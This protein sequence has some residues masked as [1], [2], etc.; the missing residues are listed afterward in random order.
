MTKKGFTCCVI[1][2]MISAATASAQSLNVNCG[3][4]TY[5][6]NPAQTG[7]MEYLNGTSLSIKGVSFNIADITSIKV[8]NDLVD[9]NTVTVNYSVDGAA[10][11]VAGNIAQ[12][13]DATVTG[14]HVSITQSDEVG[15]DTCG[16]IT[17]ILSGESTDGSF[18]LAGNYKTGVELHGVTLTNPSGAAIDIQNGK[19]VAL[20]VQ[21]GTVNNLTDGAAGSQKAALYCKG[22]LEFKQKGTLNVTGNKAHAISAKEYIQ[23]KNT[24]INIIGAQKD[25]INCNQYF[26]ME[27]GTINISNTADD[28]IQVSFKDATDREA[29]DTGTI[30][31][32]GGTLNIDVT[33]A[34]VKALKCEGDFE[35][36]KGTIN[37]TVNGGGLWDSEKLKTKASSCIGVDGN[38]NISG[39]TLVL[40]ANGAGGKGI[41]IDGDLN[42][43]GGDFTISTNGGM[44]AYVNGVINNNYTGNADNLNSDYKSSPKG[45]K[46]DGAIVID[47]GN[48]DI[49]TKGAGGEG[50]ESKSTL[51]INDGTIVIYAY[52][53]GTNSSSH[54]YLNGG[55]ITVVSKTGDAI[56]S[57]GAIYVSGG[58]IRVI[59][60]GGSEQGF[61]AGDNYTI[62]FTG[63]T[64]LA[65]GGG[66]SAPTTTD[67]STQAYVTLTQALTAGQ[68]V[69][70]SLDGDTLATFTVPA[71]YDST[72]S[73]AIMRA[74]GGNRPGGDW[75]WGGSTGSALLLSTP[76]MVSGKTYTITVDTTTTTSTAKLTGGSTGP[77]GGR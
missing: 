77:G 2:A 19:R 34:A 70:I 44:L 76:D 73:K 23:V 11:T 16:E 10:V 46:V 65:A 48:F 4:V 69:S 45:I 50:I 30:T 14:G 64:M 20:R 63:G 58:N 55:D 37:A 59:G 60:A 27:S 53:D 39:G 68:T 32:N 36:T 6:F 21:E 35:M 47:G 56:D 31:I 51:T 72:A 13:I 29:E 66:N 62:Y 67:G 49:Q 24:T 61:D 43:S 18:T 41:S 15:D 33:A 12:Y 71:S 75:G 7:V 25:G 17:Y 54:T 57:N 5:N 38:L 9:E 22:H 52:E 3:G 40:T 1:A 28:G 42:I 74:G 26:L 8:E